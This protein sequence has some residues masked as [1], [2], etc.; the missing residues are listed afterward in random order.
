M[1]LTFLP[2]NVSAR[3]ILNYGSKKSYF[4]FQDLCQTGMF[5]WM[6]HWALN[7]LYNLKKRSQ[8]MEVRQCLKVIKESTC[9]PN[10]CMPTCIEI[11]INVHTFIYSS[12][13]R[14]CSRSSYSCPSLYTSNQLEVL[15]DIYRWWYHLYIVP[16]F[17]VARCQGNVPIYPDT[18]TLLYSYGKLSSPYF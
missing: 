5:C 17:S 14:S 4:P 16:I 3:L 12:F 15:R 6:L 9:T 8:S 1:L 2:Q 13:S 11:Y 7:H 10:M 18:P